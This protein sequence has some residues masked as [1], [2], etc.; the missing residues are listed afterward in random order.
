MSSTE[1]LCVMAMCCH[2]Q[3]KTALRRESEMK[4]VEI[5]SLKS[6]AQ[7]TDAHVQKLRNFRNELVEDFRDAMRPFFAGHPATAR[8]Y[9]SCAVMHNS[10][11]VSTAQLCSGAVFSVCVQPGEGVPLLRDVTRRWFPACCISRRCT[12]LSRRP[13][14]ANGV[15]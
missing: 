13:R 8:E 1:T 6:Q 10:I 5:T 4:S 9:V 2:S 11:T 15:L 14:T 7:K 3:D 12:A